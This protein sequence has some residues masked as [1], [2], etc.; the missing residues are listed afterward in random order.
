VTSYGLDSHQT[1]DATL[2]THAP[3]GLSAA[4]GPYRAA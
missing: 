2:Q 4:A 1:D 3:R